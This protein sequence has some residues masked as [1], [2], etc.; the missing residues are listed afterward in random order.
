MI[1]MALALLVVSSPA[2]GEDRWTLFARTNNGDEFRFDTATVERTSEGVDA[3][4]RIRLGNW[5]GLLL[6]RWSYRCE[7]R[8]SAVTS[9]TVYD[10]WGNMLSFAAT[11]RAA[12]RYEQVLPDTIDQVLFRR[13][14]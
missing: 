4:V 6:Q 14:C 10:R 1:R 12:A 5:D 8:Q 13:L 3:W 2:Q 9:R 11:E 7:A